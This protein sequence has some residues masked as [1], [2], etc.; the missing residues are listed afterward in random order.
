[1]DWLQIILIILPPLLMVLGG[2][3]TWFIKSRIEELKATEKKLQE[4][5]RKIYNQIVD[6]YIRLF[7]DI[8]GQGRI[9]ALKKITSVEYRKTAF[10]L[11]F[12]GSDKAIYAYNALMQHGFEVEA[13]RKEDPKKMLTLFGNFL[14]EIRKSLGN[15]KTKLDEFDMLRA[16]IKDID[17]L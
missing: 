7:A 12:F 13:G 9:Q 16:M 2:V 14:L 10:E 11:N 3:I 8:K 17:K 4:D 1:M 5:R 15:K 6:P